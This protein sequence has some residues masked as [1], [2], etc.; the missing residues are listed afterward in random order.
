MPDNPYNVGDHVQVYLD[1]QYWK[2]EAGYS[3]TVIR[4]D[5]YSDHRSF[6]WVELDS[7]VMDVHGGIAAEL[8]IC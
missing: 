8:S 3:G 6:I 4:I 5:P 7:S 2:S 1:S